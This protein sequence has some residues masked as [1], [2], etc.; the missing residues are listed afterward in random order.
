MRL[1]LA[2]FDR[3]SIEL[4]YLSSNHSLS[5]LSATMSSANSQ[6][7]IC[8][9]NLQPLVTRYYPTEQELIQ[10]IRRAVEAQKQWTSVS[11]PERIA[12]GRKA[13]VRI[14]ELVT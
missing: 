5:S 11:L 9:H 8:P 13:V 1:K 12:I 2:Q 4:F 7:T 14:K 10:V 3:Q 6:T